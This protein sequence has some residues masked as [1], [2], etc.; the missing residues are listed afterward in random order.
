MSNYETMVLIAPTIGPEAI[1]R[2]IKSYEEVITT[3]GGTIIKIS[4]W[5]R[6]TLAYEIK[7]FKEGIYVIYEY[8]AP[9]EMIKE[10]ERRLRINDSILRF[11]TV[12]TDLKIR[13]ENKGAA[14]LQAKND[15]SK[16]RSNRSGGNTSSNSS[17]APAASADRDAR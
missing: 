5:G 8:E 7:K 6:K 1:D 4:K 15:K 16:R 14:I 9:G 13:L 17:S 10:L 2:L 12:K 11:I 3:N